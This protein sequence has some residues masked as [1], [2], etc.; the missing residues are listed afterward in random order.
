MPKPKIFLASRSPRRRKLLKRAGYSFKIVPSSYVEK[1]DSQLTPSANAMNMARGKAECACASGKTGYVLGA[2]T[3]IYFRG[4]IIGKPKNAKD[5]CR[6]LR[7]LSGKR[8]YVYT[9]LALRSLVMGEMRTSYA[10]SKVIFKKLSEKVIEDYVRKNRPL[11]KAGA[12]AI[13]EDGHKLIKAI[14]GSRSN[15]IGLP[16]ELLKSEL[17][18]FAKADAS[19]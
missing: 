11:D 10:K 18:K 9:G 2:D 8:H 13:Q 19:F 17:K 1:L 3:F 15:V 7:L 6:I 4:R 5:A 16:M 14:L 12:Y